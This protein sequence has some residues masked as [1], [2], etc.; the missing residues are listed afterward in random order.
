M[1]E[2]NRGR[3]VGSRGFTQGSRVGGERPSTSGTERPKRGLAPEEAKRLAQLATR[4]TTLQAELGEQHGF[5]LNLDD[6]L[7]FVE[8][9]PEA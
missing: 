9:Y 8:K 3:L 7:D 5:F 1:I 6:A 2:R 4:A